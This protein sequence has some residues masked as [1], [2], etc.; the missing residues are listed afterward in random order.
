MGRSITMN[1]NT[2][3]P[4]IKIFDDFGKIL[5]VLVTFFPIYSHA[6]TNN[7]S[8][9]W[10]INHTTKN[11]HGKGPLDTLRKEVFAGKSGG[12]VSQASA[13][14]GSKASLGANC[15]IAY[16]SWSVNTQATA[17]FRD[18]AAM[19]KCIKGNVSGWANVKYSSLDC[20]R[21]TQFARI[22]NA[23]KNHLCGIEQDDMDGCSNNSK[24][25][26]RN[27]A[28]AAKLWTDTCKLSKKQ[29]MLCIVK[30]SLSI[31][32]QV[33][34]KLIDAVIVEVDDKSGNFKSDLPQYQS[35]I[36]PKKIYVAYYGSR[37]SEICK[38]TKSGMH[39]IIKRNGLELDGT[40]MDCC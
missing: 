21:D 30:N 24:L 34:R 9:W 39:I 22:V 8:W 1:L 40:N 35:A 3:F 6:Q 12:S 23:G 32:K 29:G 25:N 18:Q 16:T 37:K 33:D 36:D 2:P 7:C 14:A 11:R 19:M 38:Y 13:P 26:D 27:C 17:D 20:I 5:L 15:T 10:E 28:K 31:I 4:K